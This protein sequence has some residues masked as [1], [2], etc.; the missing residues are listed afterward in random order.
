VRADGR[1]AGGSA[2]GAS[3]ALSRDM[4]LLVKTV[5]YEFRK[6]IQFRTGFFVREVL[7]GVVEPLV[8]LFVFGAIYRS[9]SPTGDAEQAVLGSW[10]YPEIVKYVAGLLIVMKLVFNNRGLDLS[11]EIFEGRITKYLT[12]PFRYFVL[13]QGRFVQFT[14]MQVMVSGLVWCIA[15]GLMGDRWL[16]PVS[17]VAT[18]QALT[19][20][21]LGSYCCFL[22]YV[23][24]NTLAFWLDVVWSLLVM[25]WFVISFTGGAVMPVSQMPAWVASTFSYAFPYWTISAP[26]EILMGRLGTDA[27]LRGVLIVG[28]QLVLLDVLRRFTWRRGLAHYVGAGM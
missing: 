26:I 21:L 23:I 18:G 2:A 6:R 9:A 15:Y 13:I 20:V 16:V 24:L 1:D 22:L 17:W 14:I 27:F 12:M 7:N 11:T 25:A 10:S 8:M 4:N 3:G 19:L 5:A 28:L